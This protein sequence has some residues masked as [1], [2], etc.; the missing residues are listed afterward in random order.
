MDEL[1][2]VIY[3]TYAY[4]RDESPEMLVIDAQPHVRMMLRRIWPA[5]VMAAQMV[6]RVIATPDRL[7]D[8]AWLMQRYPLA[9]ATRPD[10][11][12]FELALEEAREFKAR[13][14]NVVLGRAEPREFKLSKPLRPYQAMEAELV[15]QRGRL[16]IGDQ[17][18]LGKTVSTIAVVAAGCQPALIVCPTNLQTQWKTR[19]EE[20]MP[21][22]KVHIAKKTQSSPAWRGCQ[23][24]IV[25]Y[26]KLHG[27]SDE[28]QGMS[29]VAFD[30][31]QELRSPATTKRAA[32]LRLVESA[33]FVVGLSGTPVVN[34]GDEI[35]RIMEVIDPSILGSFFEF[36]REWCTVRGTHW[37]VKDPDALGA[38]LRDSGAFVRHRREEVGLYLPPVTTVVQ[39]I[40]HDP[41]RID[42]VKAQGVQLARAVLQGAF[43]ERGM[44][45]RQLEMLMR[46]QTGV[47]K[48]P[49]VAA[50]ISEMV[51]G[52][53]RPILL[54]WHRE[55]WEIC[56]AVFEATGVKSVLYTGSESVTQ[57]D[58]AVRD[59][60]AGDADVFML[61]LR[62]G[63]GIDGL[64][65][66]SS[67][68]VVGELDWSPAII[69]QAVGRVLRP[70]Q[71]N[72][73]TVVWLVSEGGSD[74]TISNIIGLKKAQARGIIDPSLVG[75][76]DDALGGAAGE[77]RA[78]DL[79]REI[80][81]HYRI[82]ADAA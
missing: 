61:S 74:P 27:W 30:E 67:L 58:K 68:V 64:Q 62:S 65:Y 37:M 38:F 40:N 16:L 53:E 32:A 56:Q 73:V 14:Q 43:T 35:Y 12:Y 15:L 2:P 25:P 23:V 77:V 33:Q 21:G 50:F 78:A 29:L 26:S 28:L 63:A 75:A 3:G 19:F 1:A 24:V 82:D 4:E 36:T 66:H 11:F 7:E 72:P 10:G 45:A 54:G 69:E 52:G 57:K 51:K 44:A 76:D 79:A 70:G 80:L 48:A 41:E 49:Y 17:V 6:M 5:T 55:F 46:Q 20:F 71:D 81:K 42:E 60:C 8:L 18:G 39:E 9:P 59:F 31:V 34:Y 22:V 47:A 13:C